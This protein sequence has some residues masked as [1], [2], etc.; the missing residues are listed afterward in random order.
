MSKLEITNDP[1]DD[2]DGLVHH[3]VEAVVGVAAW[4][5]GVEWRRHEVVDPEPI[6]GRFGQAC[7]CDDL[8]IKI[9]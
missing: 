6:F 5:G 9:V 1:F 7:H 2:R 3:P 8:L 4:G